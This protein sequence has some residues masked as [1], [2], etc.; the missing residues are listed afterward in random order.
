MSCRILIADAEALVRLGIKAVFHSV[1]DV[2]VCGEAT[3]GIDAIR[4]AHELS[5]DVIIAD[6]W[7]AG[8]NGVILARRALERHPEQK[9]LI[10]GDPVS[11]AMVCQLL[12]AGIKGLLL[13]TDPAADLI[14]AISALQEDRLYF[15]PSV[16]EAILDQYLHS[17]VPPV[18]CTPTTNHLTLREQEVAQLLAEGK[19]SKEV[20]DILGISFRTAATHRSNLM[21]KLSVH[22]SVELTLYAAAH[23][24]IQVPQSAVLADVIQLPK[25]ALRINVKAA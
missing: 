1:K 17:D 12:R 8:A 9:V 6:P 23:Q 11:D 4:K 16:E 3:D 18:E 21:R 22:N 20:G 7:L 13:K 25:P 10:F 14:D 15:T 24:L 5:A 19:A 2:V